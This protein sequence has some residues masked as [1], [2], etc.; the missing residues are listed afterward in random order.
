MSSGGAQEVANGP[1]ISF[2][3][4]EELFDAIKRWSD[5]SP[6]S[7]ER[8]ALNFITPELVISATAL[9]TEGVVVV[10]P[11][12]RTL[13]ISGIAMLPDASTNTPFAEISGS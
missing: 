5:F 3:E 8:G 10:S 12:T 2:T 13:P 11:A 1:H 4:F 6:E 9:A 7:L